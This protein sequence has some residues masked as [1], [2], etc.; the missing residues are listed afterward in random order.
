MSIVGHGRLCRIASTGMPTRRGMF[1]AIEFERDVSISAR[2][3]ETALALVI[4]DLTDGAPLLRT[5]SPCL[6]GEVLGSLRCDCR[7]LETA[8]R[9]IAEQDRGGTIYQYQEPRGIDLKAKPESYEPQDAGL[10]TVEGNHALG[11]RAD[12]R[13]FSGQHHSCVSSG[14]NGFAC[15]RTIQRKHA[16]CWRTGSRQSSDLA[17]PNPHA[18]AYLRT[19]QERM[20]HALNLRHG[21]RTGRTSDLPTAQKGECCE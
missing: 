9:A 17:V 12:C 19:K 14:S 3:V 8:T 21:D 16:P 10:Y 18:P 15:S 11:F 6:C 13:D 4:G 20:G 2:P 1:E 7:K 5:H